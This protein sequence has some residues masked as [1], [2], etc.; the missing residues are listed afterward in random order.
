[1]HDARLGRFFAVDPLAAEYSYNSPYAFSEN[2]VIHAIELEG[3]EAVLVGVN[4]QVALA[5]Q[6]GSVE[7]GVLIAPDGVFFYTT[8]ESGGSTDIASASATVSA[9]FFPTVT[10]GYEL[11]GAGRVTTLGSGAGIFTGSV[12]ASEA[13]D[14][15]GNVTHEGINVHF[16]V[17]KG[18]SALGPVSISHTYT[19]TKI[20]PLFGWSLTYSQKQEVIHGVNGLR[21]SEKAELRLEMTEKILER[22]KVNDKIKDSSKSSAEEAWS[23]LDVSAKLTKEIDGLKSEMKEVD[24]KYDKVIETVENNDPH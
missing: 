15:N 23:L 16:G 3:L 19:D 6:T 22:T 21:K 20:Y 13:L 17:G 11:K 12:S 5:G 9:T 1:M 4:G 24:N 8:V 7:G 10:S 14:D 2:M 18:I